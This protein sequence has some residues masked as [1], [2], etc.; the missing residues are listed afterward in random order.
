MPRNLPLTSSSKN[1]ET[2]SSNP[3]D[4]ALAKPDNEELFYTASVH[5]L[6]K[7]LQDK[8]QS[9]I[10]SES[11][12]ISHSCCNL[13]KNSE[14]PLAFTQEKPDSRENLSTQSST[15]LSMHQILPFP[16]SNKESVVARIMN[17]LR[18]YKRRNNIPEDKTD[19]LEL[20]KPRSNYKFPRC[21]RLNKG[22]SSCLKA[23][24]EELS[25][26]ALNSRKSKRQNTRTEYSQECFSDHGT[27]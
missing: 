22:H 16:K 21:E 24:S 9:L 14:N 26:E 17:S 1:T 25:K 3:L 23:I 8:A 12:H 11:R 2:T 18:K 6:Q 13:R 15:S 5:F 20:F 19:D 27:K 10:A 4:F 7:R